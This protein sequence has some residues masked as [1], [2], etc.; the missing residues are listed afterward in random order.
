MNK[1]EAIYRKSKDCKD[2]ETVT[3]DFLIKRI[4]LETLHHFV[5][6]DGG[7]LGL[8]IGCGSGFQS[9]LLSC[10]V[11]KLIATDMP[12]FNP[13]THSRGIDVAGK[14]LAKLDVRNV[15]LVSCSGECLP[16]SDGTFDFVFSM[17]VL[18]HINDKG[19][20][21]R[22]M[23]RVLK[24]DG[25]VI[26]CV[27]THIAS[28]FAFPHL[29]LYTVKRAVDVIKAK[30]LYK[31]ISKNS[32]ALA[33]L[34]NSSSRASNDILNSFRKSHPSFPAPEPHG[35]YKDIFQEFNQQLPWNWIKLARKNGARSTDTFALLFLPFNILEIFS[36]RAIAWLYLKTRYLHYIFGRTFLQYFCYSWCVVAKK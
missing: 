14:L 33:G 25:M 24:P 9:A 6:L 2:F 31:T 32:A 12:S 10:Q 8:E 36:T 34:E 21:L 23:F 29:F 1:I 35:S 17:A 13:Q 28:L 19:L 26:F 22:E 7:S 16:F 27:P 15:K 18:E 3:G 4:L 5:K 11:K 20:A 30:I